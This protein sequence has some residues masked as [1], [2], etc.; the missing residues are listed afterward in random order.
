M[1][2]TFTPLN[3]AGALVHVYTDGTVLVTHGG[4][5]MGQG[6]TPRSCAPVAGPSLMARAGL[7]T[8]IVQIAAAELGVPVEHVYV[9]ETSTDKVANTAPTAASVSSDILTALFYSLLRRGPIQKPLTLPVHIN[10]MAV[11]IACRQVSERLRPLRD[12][13]PEKSF[14]EACP[15]VAC[16]RSTP[17]PPCTDH[18]DGVS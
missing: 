13:H 8:K 1:S 12:A 6:A 11:L 4:C 2:F 10:G 14:H 7:H 16:V 9:A 3:Q 17:H 15:L 18:R 5:E